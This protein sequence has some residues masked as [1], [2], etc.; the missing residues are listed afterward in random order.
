VSSGRL[1]TLSFAAPTSGTKAFGRHAAGGDRGTAV[2]LVGWGLGDL[3]AWPG[4]PR[5][6]GERALFGRRFR[7][8]F[9]AGAG[10]RWCFE[11]GPPTPNALAC[12]SLETSGGPRS[13]YVT[14]T[15]PSQRSPFLSVSGRLPPWFRG[16]RRHLRWPP[17]RFPQAP[18]LS[19]KPGGRE[20]AGEHE[21]PP[22][23]PV[24]WR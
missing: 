12:G 21:Q 15:V 8:A 22:A 2:D 23:R 11:S 10:G 18:E 1:G 14:E 16:K 13:G 20:E 19:R 5:T 7:R 24:C 9:P 3:E 17:K 4:M 6:S